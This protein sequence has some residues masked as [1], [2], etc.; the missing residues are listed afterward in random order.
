MFAGA[1]SKLLAV[2]RMKRSVGVEKLG[3]GV[4]RMNSAAAPYTPHRQ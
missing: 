2:T 1:Y 3:N 4:K